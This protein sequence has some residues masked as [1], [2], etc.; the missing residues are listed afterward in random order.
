MD[1][2]KEEVAK[3]GEEEEATK[4]MGNMKAEEEADVVSESGSLL[5]I[6]YAR[7]NPR[8]PKPQMPL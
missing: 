5:P 6:S 8:R 3:D 7:G 4:N 1:G 2:R